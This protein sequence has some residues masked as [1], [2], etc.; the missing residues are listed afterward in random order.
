MSFSWC[1]NLTD[2]TEII[3]FFRSRGKRSCK[4][5]DNYLLLYKNLCQYRSLKL[6]AAL[7]QDLKNCWEHEPNLVGYLFPILYSWYDNETVG[8]VEILRTVVSALDPY[9]LQENMWRI[10]QDEFVIVE[11]SSLVP[12]LSKYKCKYAYL[13]ECTYLK[14]FYAYTWQYFYYFSQ[15][16]R[17]G[18]VGAALCLAV[19]VLPFVL[20]SRRLFAFN[21]S[22]G[23]QK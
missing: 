19:V 2:C 18:D 13:D 1:L 3:I 22:V 21:S 16:L 8:S 7:Y 20:H 5:L 14:K 6:E 15:N 9:Q 4:N 17:L 12:L 11:D 23:C 10:L